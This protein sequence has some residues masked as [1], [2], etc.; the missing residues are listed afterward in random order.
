[1]KHLAYL[2]VLLLVLLAA[3]ARPEDSPADSRLHAKLRTLN[4]KDFFLHVAR[5]ERRLGEAPPGGPRAGARRQR[6]VADAGE[7]AAQ[8]GHPRQDR[9]RRLHHREGLLRQLSRA[10]TSAATSIGPRARPASCPASSARTATGPTAAS[11][12]PAR[13]PSTPRS[14]QGA[15]KTPEGATLS[16]AGPLRPARPHGLRRLPLRH[17]RLRRQ[18]GRSRTAPASPMP[19]PSCACRASWACKPGTASAPSTSC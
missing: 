19:R 15:E 8:A 12:R 1:M 16:A 11:T 3:P 17:G 13:R 6:S 5:H 14:K 18:Q 9:P 7:D 10:T 4:D 2:P